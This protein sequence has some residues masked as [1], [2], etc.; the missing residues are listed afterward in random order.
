MSRVTESSRG[1]TG[2]AVGRPTCAR[3]YF[4]LPA[5]EFYFWLP[6]GAEAIAAVRKRALSRTTCAAVA[7]ASGEAHAMFLHTCP[8]RPS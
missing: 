7:A 6:A 5:G 3:F 2:P 4:W 8:L 1:R